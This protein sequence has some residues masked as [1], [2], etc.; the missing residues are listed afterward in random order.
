MVV[1][2]EYLLKKTWNGFEASRFFKEKTPRMVNDF[3]DFRFLKKNE[4][5][6]MM[7]EKK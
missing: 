2:F 7:N 5:L 3:R 4:N 1:I 6:E